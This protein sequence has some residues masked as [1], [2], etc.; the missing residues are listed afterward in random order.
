VVEVVR[1][2]SHY[3]LAYHFTPLVEEDGTVREILAV[4]NDMTGVV[5]DERRMRRLNR[6]LQAISAANSVL[7]RATDETGLLRDFCAELAEQTGHRLIWVGMHDSEGEFRMVARDGRPADRVREIPFH[8]S[9]LAGKKSCLA[10]AVLTSGRPVTCADFQTDARFPGCEPWARSAGL[11]AAVGLPLPGEGG[12]LGALLLYSGEP[13]QFDSEEVTLLMELASDLAFGIVALRHKEQ[14]RVTAERLRASEERLRTFKEVMD[15]SSSVAYVTRAEP[16]WPVEFV[17]DNITRYGY[18]PEDFTSGRVTTAMVVHPDDLPKLADVTQRAVA[19]HESEYTLEYRLL[20]AA[21]QIHWMQDWCRVVRNEQGEPVRF[22]GVFTDVTEQR[23]AEALV[24]GTLDAMSETICILDANGRIVHVNESWRRFAA[25]NPPAP[26]GIGVGD[27]YFRACERA[28]GTADGEDARRFLAGARA[29]LEGQQPEFELEYACHSPQVQR[30]FLVKTTPFPVGDTPHLVVAHAEITNLKRSEAAIRTSEAKFRASFDNMMDGLLLAS[31]DGQILNANPAACAMLGWTE[32]EICAGG[33]RLIVDPADTRLPELVRE[34]ERSGRVRGELRLVRKDGTCF[35]VELTSLVFPTPEGPR[36]GVV[37]RDISER[38]QL[39]AALHRRERIMAAVN[40]AAGQFLCVAHWLDA[41]PAVLA[42]LG[43][44]AGVSRVVLWDQRAGADGEVLISQR[45][46]WAVPSLPSRVNDPTV[47]A[48]PLRAAGFQRWEEMLSRGELIHGLVRD[49]PAGESRVLSHHQIISKAVVPIMVRGQWWGFIAFDDCETER[50][51]QPAEIEALQMAA[52]VLGQAIQN[53]Q[54]GAALR[55][56]ERL[57]AQAEHAGR[58]GGWEV[59]V[60]TGKQQWTE[61]VYELH[62]V[63][64]TFEPTVENGIAFYAPESRPVIARAVRRAIEQG[65]P[66]D[67][68]LDIITAKGNRRSVHANGQAGEGK[69]FGSF[70]DITK[71]KQA[72]LQKAASEARLSFTLQACHVGAWDLNLE[73]HSSHRTL[74]HDRIFGYS[75]LLPDW[76]YERF[77]EHV[78]PEDR[79]KVEQ[80]FREA[81]ATHQDWNFECRIR[82]ADGE[83]RWI[84]AAGGHEQPLYGGPAFLT[85]IVQDITERKQVEM[86]LRASEERLRRVSDTAAVGLT[87]LNRDWVYLSANPAYAEIAGVP[88]ERIIGS[89]MV[90]VMGKAAAEKIRPY[91]ERVLRGECVEYEIEL[92]WAA[93]SLRHIHVNYTPDTD[94]TGEIV[95]WVASV[96]DITERKS[97]EKQFLRAQRMEGIGLL[98]GGIAHD[99]NNVLAPILMGADLLKLTAPNEQVAHQLDGIVQSAKR[100]AD[101]VKQVLTFARGIEGDRIPVQPKHVIKEMVR[102]ARETFP[103]NLRFNVDVPNGLWPVVGDPTQLHQV[104]LNLSVNA[105]DALPDGGE[106][107][108]R[109]RN[110]EVDG[111]LAAANPGAHPGPHVVLQV[112]DTGTGMPTEVLD[113]IFEPFFTTKELGKGTG[114]GLSTALG[115]VHSHGGFITVR[116]EPFRGTSFEVYLPAT[117]QSAAAAATAAPEPLPVGEGELV[118]LV[119]DE[120]AILEVARTMLETHGYRVATAEDGT[121]ALAELSRWEGKV[122]VLLTDILMP[123][124]DGTQLI[125]AVRRIAPQLPV[126]V[127]TGATHGPGQPDRADEL[128]ALGVRQILRK[129]CTVETLLRAVRD[130]LHPP[131]QTTFHR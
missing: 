116:S 58:I 83:V 65:E 74:L 102:M 37:F 21:G 68:D 1:D 92:P 115:I 103:P 26:A 72:E 64:P 129:P 51:W 61:M 28:Q 7:V 127:C 97:L 108:Y 32:A 54:A 3:H 19:E 35:D 16:G 101:I 20:D 76:T 9:E 82:R 23:Q 22:Q 107:R 36:T 91:V 40:A 111:A 121:T 44:A 120:P 114:L 34:R 67:L 31:P 56:S 47:Q 73:D 85:G 17:S 41:L 18:Q 70:Q 128:R 33:R 24:R 80:S 119:E 100:G 88:L 14:L 106:L 104:L 4:T 131:G 89:T 50:A 27:S 94:A 53:E 2:G 69:I 71:R 12:L 62:E 130:A 11:R 59:D 57:R 45:Q 113:R 29:V 5:R 42:R 95:G 6:T 52:S 8:C 125:R 78:L 110:T 43:E 46:E 105:R 84:W 30:W 126:I 123:F 124:M 122:A 48:F 13:D 109:A 25:A 86:E 60:A 49:F 96:T 38:K 99:L 39:E 93:R 66:F 79:A 63:E 98:A 117:P 87:R 90:E 77:L 112:E 118:L 15:H 10:D 75:T 81:T 55:R